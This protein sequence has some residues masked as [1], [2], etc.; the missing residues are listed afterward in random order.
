MFLV[1]LRLLL[2]A[3][4]EW[5]ASQTFTETNDLLGVA[6]NKDCTA[7]VSGE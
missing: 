6:V 7:I 2:S 1:F 5:Q 4:T 3:D